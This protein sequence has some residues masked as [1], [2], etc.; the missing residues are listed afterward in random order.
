MI[1]QCLTS[2]RRSRNR[3]QQTISIAQVPLPTASPL[4]IEHNRSALNRISTISSTPSDVKSR[5]TDTST[6]LNTPL[7]RYPTTYSRSSTSASSSYY[8]FPNELE[9]LCK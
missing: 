2:I 1:C 8:M 3:Q 6:V 9:Q 5:C 7:N 4:L